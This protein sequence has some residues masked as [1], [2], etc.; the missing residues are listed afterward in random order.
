[1]GCISF[2]F[3]L[4]PRGKRGWKTF[5][6]VLKGT[7]LYLQKVKEIAFFEGDKAR[8]PNP[9]LLEPPFSWAPALASQDPHGTSPVRTQILSLPVTLT[10]SLSL[11]LN[12][13]HPYSSAAVIHGFTRSALPVKTTSSA[14]LSHT[15][16]RATFHAACVYGPSFLN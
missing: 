16:L 4:A 14:C 10:T 12:S 11:F 8:V 15:Y 1:M 7:V 2:V 9:F 6:A 3:S 5:Y 13:A